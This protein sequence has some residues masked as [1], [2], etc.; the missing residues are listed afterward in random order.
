MDLAGLDGG[1]PSRLVFAQVESTTSLPLLGAAV[2]VVGL[3]HGMVVPSITAAAYQRLSKAAIPAATTGANIMVRVGSALGGA[4]LAIILQIRVREAIPGA[5][6]I[7]TTGHAAQL[8]H[9]FAGSF[10]WA[11]GIAAVALIPAL[12]LP[13][14]R[15]ATPQPPAAV[16]HDVK[17]VGAGA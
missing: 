6:G 14:P 9:A 1:H 11:F 12:F 3:G 7:Q 16:S 10:W 8:A 15:R 5:D 4:V 2:F 17:G 13:T